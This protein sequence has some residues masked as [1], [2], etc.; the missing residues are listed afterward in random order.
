L[1]IV[2]GGPAGLTLA[3]ALDR[4]G[5]TIVL[6]ES[7]GARPEEGGASELNAGIMAGDPLADLRVSRAR[8]IGG[9][10]ALW[11]T[12]RRGV[13]GAKYVPLDPVD[14]ESRPELP[15]SGWPFGRR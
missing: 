12:V 6:I 9:T 1:C 5:F 2:G 7:G 14:L 4:E 11:N 10:A 8:G 15:W 3:D 13:P